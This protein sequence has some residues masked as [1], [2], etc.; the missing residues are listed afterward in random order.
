MNTTIT[1]YLTFEG[2]CREA[3]TFYQE[4]LGGKLFFQTIGDSPLGSRL[5]D[6]IKKYILN[7]TLING[8]LTIVASDMV[9]ESGLLKGNS[10]SL[11]LCCS[12]AAEASEYF[13][14]L[15]ADGRATDPLV[16]TFSGSLFGGLVDK[17][18]NHWLF[19]CEDFNG[20]LKSG[21]R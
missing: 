15:S 18:G 7:A 11:L 19:S 4:C 1:S 9:P 21:D 10:V 13:I 2:N 17:F 12:N 16:H 5:P 14:K 20:K 6:E 8:K 3:M